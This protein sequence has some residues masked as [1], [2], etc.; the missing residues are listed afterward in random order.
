MIAAL[1]LLAQA[2][3]ILDE[4]QGLIVFEAESVP[5]KGD[6]TLE[7]S[8]AGF[9]GAGYVTWTGPDLFGAPGKDAAAWTFRVGRPGRYRLR[10][11]N[12]HD[13]A[14]STLQNDCFTKMDDGPWIKTFSSKRGEWTWA[15][16][17]ELENGKPPAAYELSVGTHVFRISGRSRG[18]SLDRIHLALEGVDGAEDASRAPSKSLHESM[19]GPGPYVR[20]APLARRARSGRGLGQILREA[21]AQSAEPEG[22]ALA[23]ALEAFADRRRAEAS[24]A[25]PAER[26]R[27][28]EELAEQFEGD[29]RGAE[30]AKEAAA[31]RA[32]PAVEGELKA[33][34]Q[35]ARVEE[36][37]SRLKPHQGSR[38]VASEP[39]RRLNAAALAGIAAGCR[40]IAKSW[41]GTRA[42]RRAEELLARLR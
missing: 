4:A 11:R 41:P 27:R 19:V 29:E 5:P 12:R 36:A 16:N 32:D 33:S 22:R 26:V 15:T 17:H 30:A 21:R 24:E 38:D 20:L 35:W 18:F 8:L 6:W 28:L 9:T 14:D 13:F 40:Q 2:E 37:L 25:E 39:V 31:L 1:L 42:A 23:E 34:A 3:A 7:T 10:I